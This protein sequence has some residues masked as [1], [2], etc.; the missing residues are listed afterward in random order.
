[1][2]SRNYKNV[3][4]LIGIAVT[5]AAVSGFG[6]SRALGCPAGP[7]GTLAPY[8]PPDTAA[9]QVALPAHMAELDGDARKAA[10][11]EALGPLIDAAN[12]PILRDRAVLLA[13]ANQAEQG[14]DP[15]IGAH[16]WLRAIAQ[17]YGAEPDDFA[18]LLRRIDIVPP[19]LA[20]TQAA[21]ESGWGTSRFTQD[22]NAL[23]GQRTYSHRT[24]GIKPADA[25]G[26]R[27]RAFAS[28]L[29]SVEHYIHN[30]NTHPAY[31]EFRVQRALQRVNGVAVSGPEL[32][33][34]LSAYSELGGAYVDLL[35][36]VIDDNDLAQLDGAFHRAFR[37]YSS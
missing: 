9:A 1:M 2:L 7:V 31:H 25:D 3:A 6:I 24:P 20:L 19:S 18:T 4:L 36:Q 30:L 37:R 10:F 15:G 29:Q 14:C 34:A 5:A 23:F 22:A 27:V 35:L 21:I 33:A 32:A 8:G 17:R 12:E 28:L 26:F 11:Q 13:L 16:V